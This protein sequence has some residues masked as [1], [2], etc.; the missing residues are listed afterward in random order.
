ME[1][2]QQAKKT[3]TMRSLLQKERQKEELQSHKSN[4]VSPFLATAPPQPHT[5][6][7]FSSTRVK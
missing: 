1:R 5:F 3:K 2:Y 4:S 7:S 6:F